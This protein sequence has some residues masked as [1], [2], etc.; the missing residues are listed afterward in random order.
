MSESENNSS[1][2]A[3][4]ATHVVGT[5]ND[6]KMSDGYIDEN[7]NQIGAEEGGH[8][9]VNGH[10]GSDEIS[11][12]DGNDLAAGDMV[13]DEWQFVDGKWVYNAADFDTTSAPVIRD[14]DD[15]ITTGSGDDVLLGNGG[16]DILNSGT[17]DDIINAGTGDDRAFGGKGNDI[18]N[19]EAGNDYAEGGVGNDTINGGEGNDTIYGDVNEGSVITNAEGATTLDQYI[20]HGEWNFTETDQYE[21][22][23]HSID[24]DE[25]D[26][27]EITFELAANLAGGHGSGKV[28]VL[29]NGDV[30][31]TVSTSTGVY[32]KHTF[33]V[34]GQPDSSEL[35]FRVLEPE[36]DPNAPVYDFSG[37]VVS[38]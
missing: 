29:W 27:F 10:A 12:G 33:E 15:V 37:P 8:D 14:Y 34:N 3:A 36:P 22:I 23:S 28:E 16:N 1:N 2:A 9:K 25:S 35:S 13:G 7:E 30:V 19:L 4:V 21:Q 6:D 32:E 11:T 17:G 31:G 5:A 18:I 24:T 20:E 26:K 38:L